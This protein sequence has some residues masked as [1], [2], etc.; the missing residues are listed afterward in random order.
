[1]DRCKT[2]PPRCCN[3][4]MANVLLGLEGE[5]YHYTSGLP[6]SAHCEHEKC[7]RDLRR[8]VPGN[9]CQDTRL[10]RR[11]FVVL[12]CRITEMTVD[13]IPVQLAGSGAVAANV[14]KNYGSATTGNRDCRGAMKAQMLCASS[15]RAVCDFSRLVKHRVAN[16]GGRQRLCRA[17]DYGR[18]VYRA[19]WRRHCA[20]NVPGTINSMVC[21]A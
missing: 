19:A 12:P 13:L 3:S 1:M 20:S 4:Q 8:E 18:S 5:H 10:R 2:R 14:S 15:A 11:R 9:P 17:H 6:P 16:V 7:Q 21:S